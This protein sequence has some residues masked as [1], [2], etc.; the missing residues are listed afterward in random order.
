MK[1]EKTALLVILA[2]VIGISIGLT[3]TLIK[4]CPECRCESK[5]CPDIVCP[6]FDCP[7]LK[8]ADIIYPEVKTDVCQ[9]TV[10]E[11]CDNGVNGKILCNQNEYAYTYDNGICVC[12]A[13]EC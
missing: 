8:C 9:K 4:P 13:K 10:N 1:K 12:K 5:S 2:L 7:D 6:G 11:S 3:I